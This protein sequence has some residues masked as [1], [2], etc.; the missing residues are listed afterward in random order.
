L[1]RH[2]LSRNAVISVIPVIRALLS[3]CGFDLFT[4]DVQLGIV[5][6]QDT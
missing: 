1:W 5:V 3:G 6:G 4:G 2:I